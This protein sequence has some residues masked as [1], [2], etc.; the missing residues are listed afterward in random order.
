MIGLHNVWQLSLHVQLVVLFNSVDV[1]LRH[2]HLVVTDQDH[3]LLVRV[4][5]LPELGHLECF[6]IRGPFA[7]R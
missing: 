3:I 1:E 5:R 7:R 2:G 4:L 6:I